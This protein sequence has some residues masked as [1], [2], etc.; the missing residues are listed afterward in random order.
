MNDSL[1]HLHDT[2]FSNTQLLG[3]DFFMSLL[4]SELSFPLTWSKLC[5]SLRFLRIPDVIAE[6]EK[7][8]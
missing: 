7:I 3:D 1:E 8:E 5:S 4:T 2:A 6:R